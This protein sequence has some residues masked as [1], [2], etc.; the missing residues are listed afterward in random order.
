KDR[1][2]DIITHSFLQHNSL[3]F[4]PEILSE[5]FKNLCTAD[6][7]SIPPLYTTVQQVCKYWR[8]SSHAD[9]TL[10]STIYIQHPEQSHVGM[11][12]VALSRAKGLPLDWT[13]E[14][15]PFWYAN[16]D[17][18]CAIF[19]LLLKHI[20]R[21]RNV[22]LVLESFDDPIP[23]A[24]RPIMREQA[25]WPADS[26]LQSLNIFFPSIM[27]HTSR[28]H[29]FCTEANNIPSLTCYSIIRPKLVYEDYHMYT[30][31]SNNLNISVSTSF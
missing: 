19:E 4:P 21:W 31:F 20:A 6:Y 3:H 16:G 11:V 25:S 30:I 24:M 23:W 26:I 1:P 15:G 8:D 28:F 22:R 7:G 27:Q 17:A 18:V 13:V 9:P 2:V 29:Q 10:W 12:E 14:R 5:V